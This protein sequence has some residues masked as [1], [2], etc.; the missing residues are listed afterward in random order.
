M[1][2]MTDNNG[3]RRSHAL[4]RWATA[5]SAPPRAF[6]VLELL[7]A[8]AIIGL[9]AA[10]LLPALMAA[11]EAARRTACSNHLRQL[12]TAFQLHHDRAGALPAAWRQASADKQFAY[13]WATQILPDLEQG[14][15]ARQLNNSA[16]PATSSV[17]QENALPEL[18][19]PSDIT[20]PFFDLWKEAAADD[21]AAAISVVAAEESDHDDSE[22]GAPLI[23][24]PT[25][26]YQGVFGN[27]D[28]YLR[29]QRRGRHLMH[30]A[31]GAR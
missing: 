28:P 10:L 3:I 15:L 4:A 16:R 11:R 27:A 8:I 22:L 2:R 12:G 30:G 1:Q 14:N 31:A 5:Q 6:T 26:N 21:P 13:G 19:C 7:V 24:L 9:L 20:E 18:I 25:A 29:N 23:R 17:Q